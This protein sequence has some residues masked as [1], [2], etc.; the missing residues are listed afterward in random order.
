[1]THDFACAACRRG[2]G[3]LLASVVLVSPLA[4]AGPGFG[5]GGGVTD[6]IDGE[7][8]AVL[9]MS[10]LGRGRH[11]WEFSAGR[12]GA[13]DDVEPLPV[14]AT[15]FIAVSKRLTWRRW[16]VSGGI[17]LSDHD[18]AVLSGHGQFYTGVGYTT[19]AWTAS[20]RHLSN[21][22]TGGRNRGESFALVEYRW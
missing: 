3:A 13:R 14:P 18:G 10:W 5:I 11:P 12:L 19:G 9:T 20:L 7:R 1:M 2:C 21:G 16:F 15:W 17:A 8:T 6:E 4:H 22:D